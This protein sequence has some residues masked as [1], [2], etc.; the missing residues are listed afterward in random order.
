[1]SMAYITKTYI[2]SADLSAIACIAAESM[3][4]PAKW[5]TDALATDE[6]GHPVS[7]YSSKAVILSE[8]HIYKAAQKHFGLGVD[9]EVFDGENKQTVRIN[10]AVNQLDAQV[11][12]LDHEKHPNE[13]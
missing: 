3:K 6:S 1:M 8:G 9:D 5:T 7:V 12:F 13:E 4:D 10:A 2:S 11:R